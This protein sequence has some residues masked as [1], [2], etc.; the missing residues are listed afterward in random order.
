[1]SDI[2]QPLRSEVPER[3]T[4][5]LST[6]FPSQEAFEAEFAAVKALIPGLGAWQGKLTRSG[7]QILGNRRMSIDGEPGFNTSEYLTCLFR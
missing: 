3:L 5:N 1:M 4:W 2:N 6:I 7:K